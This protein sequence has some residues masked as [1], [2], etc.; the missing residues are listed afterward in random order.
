MCLKMIRC[1]LSRV[2]VVLIIQLK[3]VAG[4][5]FNYS[6]YG[7][8]LVSAV[9]EGAAGGTDFSTAGELGNNSN[10][11]RFK[12]FLPSFPFYIQDALVNNCCK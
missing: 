3:P 7:Y 6:T 4:T 11:T 2:W 12:T 9:C 8:T 10:L 5:E 1:W